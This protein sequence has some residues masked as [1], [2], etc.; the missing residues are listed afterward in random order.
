LEAEQPVSACA[1]AIIRLL[2]TDMNIEVLLF[3]KGKT[4]HF[5]VG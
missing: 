3:K 2:Y 5:T 1:R 4:F